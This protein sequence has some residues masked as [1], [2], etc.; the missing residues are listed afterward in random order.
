MKS[1]ALI[2]LVILSAMEVTG[3]GGGSSG[4]APA[5]PSNPVPSISS[6]SPSSTTA[7]GAAFTLTVNGSN[8]I[9]SSTVEW[10]GSSL[11]TTFVS[12]TQLTAAVTA[13]NT[14]AAGNANI[15]VTNPSPGGGTS[16]AVSFAVNNPLPVISSLSPASVSTGGARFTL[17]I[18][19][20]GFVTGSTVAWNGSTLTATYVSATQLTASI[21]ASDIATS[22]NAAVTVANPAP[23][24]GSSAEATFAVN[25][26]APSALSLSPSTA[27][28]G[29]A[30]F[31][32]TVNGSNFLPSSTVQWNGSYGQPPLST[33]YVSSTQLTVAIPASD[34]AFAGNANVT[35]VNS[36]PGGGISQPAVFTITGSIPND[37][38]FVAANGNDSNPGTI[39]QP[40]LTIQMCATTVSSGS[41]CAIRA[42]TYRETVT[43]NSGITITSYDGEPVTVDGSNPVTGWSL[44]QGSI[45]Q[46]KVTLASD[47]SNQIF[48]DSQMMTEARWPN[49]ND[50]F[51]VNWATAQTGTTTTQIVDPSLPGIDWTGAKIHIWSGTDAW[52]PQTG[53]VTASPTGQLTFTVDGASFPPYIQPQAGG[54][55]YLYRTLVAL[56][57]QDQWY[58]DPATTTLYF[59]APGGVNPGTL[60]VLAKQRQY[61]FDLSGQS[62]VT[63][64]YV[65]LFANSINMDASSANNTLD[66]IDAQYLSQFTDLPETA[67]Y[68]SSYW[69]DYTATSGIIINGTGNVLENSTI[70]YSA[71]N[72]VA[73]SGSN[74]TIQNNLIQYSDYAANYCSGITFTYQA[75]TGNEIQNNTIESDGRF[76]ID[77]LAGTNEDISYNNFFNA[78]M[79]SRD[80]GEIYLGGLSATG[81]NIHNNWF[82]D[83]Q[84]MYTSLDYFTAGMSGIYLDEDSSDVNVEQNIFWN[85]QYYNIFVNGSNDGTTSPNNNSIQ[86][87]TIP[88]VNSTGDIFTDLTAACG[89]T[90]IVNNLVLVPVTQDGTVCTATNN[91]STAPG[92]TQMTSSVQVGCNFAGCSSEGPPTISG[93]SV[94]A[95]I[96]VQPY[97][98]TVAAGQSAT[99]TVT[100]AGSPTLTYQWQRN[101]SDISGATSASYTIPA[102]TSADN[103][104]VFTVIVGNPIGTVTS[105]PAT[106]TVN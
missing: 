33:A 55:Y 70:A 90:Q 62:N 68:P 19:G 31:T 12:E 37:V 16:S 103:G 61:A 24:G 13:T 77:Y 7:G 85:N 104:S 51:H 54:L 47:D 26:P 41:T 79:V 53:T 97:S 57:A 11:T 60:N 4:S 15:A 42:G 58:Y 5:P 34:I 59:W 46:A 83:T 17:T 45:Y 29:D 73:L 20:T 36:S 67:G 49:G 82:H 40:Y 101:G 66:G 105:N 76:G 9:S 72:G 96:A 30:G 18:N 64:E 78:M 80:G 32:L 89:T 81:T 22:Q 43:P 56:T 93:T 75:G 14:A 102:A 21:P 3:C 95:S 88:D 10:N 106:L 2:A 69:Y 25:S 6:L 98:M 27:A 8:F 48:V 87:N 99:F 84:T 74:N 100:A 91:S 44:Y 65:N 92:A 71:G 86:N 52:D 50:L 38:S 39:A 63:I 1:P 94:S 28:A 23:G 35:V